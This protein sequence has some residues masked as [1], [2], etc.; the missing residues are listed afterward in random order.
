[1]NAAGRALRAAGVAASLALGAV[2]LFAS[3][4]RAV[5]VGERAPEFALPGIDGRIHALAELRGRVVY[6][7][8]W[9]SWC[10]PCR[11]SFPWMNGMHRRYAARGLSIVA[12]N[13]DRERSAAERFLER[14]PADF[15]IA[16]DPKG[17]SPAAFGVRGMPSAY[18]I[19]G[20]GTVVR[21]EEGFRDERTPAL[22]AQIRTLLGAPP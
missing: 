19:D 2:L 18:L 17:E 11:R 7:D 21:V 10:A 1:M 13:V 14:T 5:G 3:A 12:I 20:S 6:V 15:P 4:A 9:A 16:L 22:E 8:F